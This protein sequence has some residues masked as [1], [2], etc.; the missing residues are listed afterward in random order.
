MSDLYIGHEGVE[1]ELDASQHTP[2]EEFDTEASQAL[3]QMRDKASDFLSLEPPEVRLV[4][5]DSPGCKYSF[6]RK[7]I[8]M[9]FYWTDDQA[10]QE[11]L[12]AIRLDNDSKEWIA[13]RFAFMHEFAHHFQAQFVTYTTVEKCKVLFECHAD[14]I[15]AWLMQNHIFAGDVQANARFM[16]M[17]ASSLQGQKST[18][19]DHPTGCVRSFAVARGLLPDRWKLDAEG[20]LLDREEFFMRSLQV[21]FELLFNQRYCDLGRETCYGCRGAVVFRNFQ[22]FDGS[23]LNTECTQEFA[24]GLAGLALGSRGAST[25]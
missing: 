25:L 14:V 8:L 18:H 16:V 12:K 2:L 24:E 10:K 21:A 7:T 5:G 4:V 17:L 23:Q 6:L 22:A 9:N 11:A 20:H 3:G 1:A 15:A 19:A 13:L